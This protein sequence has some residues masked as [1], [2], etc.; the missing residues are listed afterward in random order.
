VRE[1]ILNAWLAAWLALLPC[2]A[3]AAGL[4]KLTMLSALGQPLHAEIELVSVSAQEMAGLTARLASPEDYQKRNLQ[5]SG[6]LAGARVSVEKRAD[7]RPYLRI[8]STRPVSEPFIDLLVELSWPSGRLVREYTALLDPPGVAPS[9]PVAAPEVKPAQ[10][11]AAAVP[12]AAPPPAPAPAPAAAGPIVG[13]KQYG[14]IERGETLARIARSVVPEGVTLEQMLVG[15]YRANPDV[16]IRNNINLIR[17]GKILRIPDRDELAGIPQAEAVKVY[18]AHVADWN[19]YRQQLAET[20]GARPAEGGTAVAG[21]IATRVEEK[22]ASGPRDVV[23]VS[24]GEAPRGAVADKPGT[25]AERIRNL[26]EE[27]VAREKALAEA[28]ERIA[29][30]EKTIKDMQK[31]LEL[32][33]PGLAAAQQQAEKAQAAAKPEPKP[34]EEAAPVKPEPKP[35]EQAAPAKPEAVAAAEQP[36][37]KPKPKPKAAEPPPPPPE[38]DLI[39]QILDEPLY[40]AAAAGGGVL[41]VGGVALWMVRRRRERSGPAEAV[42]PSEEPALAFAG[43]AAGAAETAQAA[44]AVAAAGAA[45]DEVD[46]VAEAEVYIAYGRDAQAEEILKEALANTPGRQDV[47]LKLLEIYAA[48]KDKTAFGN[49]ARELNQLTGGTGENWLKAAAMGYALDPDNPL[50]AAGRGA[51]APA[52]AAATASDVD[53]DLGAAAA[54]TTTTDITLDAEPETSTTVLE[55]GKGQD[56]PTRASRAEEEP[57]G[58]LMPDFTLEVPPAGEEPTRTEVY[59]GAGPDTGIDFR[60]DEPQPAGPQAAAPAQAASEGGLDFKLDLPEIDLNL[61]EEPK[62]EIRGGAAEKDGH[63]YDVQSK[64]D[65]AKA[66]QEMGDKEG[67]KEI[68][69]EVIQEGDDEQKA[70][71]K[72][73]LDSLG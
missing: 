39:A 15:L 28:N 3:G 42:A 30:L 18:R 68:L 61:A 70:Q 33:S 14:P 59:R 12:A 34:R 24:K 10:P 2:A 66:Y 73:L 60:L 29:Q 13:A 19:A 55:P 44:P 50:Y 45:V 31:L 72:A 65:L 52:L 27:L 4:G 9:P 69:R 38:P 26:E 47:Q 22:D 56:V 63:W 57:A 6:A 48:R 8:T 17:S 54:G 64:F 25:T 40:L 16:F 67:A 37:P 46:P 20:A 36:K 71:A 62:T 21:R 49:V 11:P 1:R 35:Q 5:Y 53:F 43:A 23:R 32:K 58:P 41:V 51:A 7:G